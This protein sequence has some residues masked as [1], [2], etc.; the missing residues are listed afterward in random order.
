MLTEIFILKQTFSSIK[1]HTKCNLNFRLV[2]FPSADPGR[3]ENSD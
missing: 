3:E 1:Q 2:G